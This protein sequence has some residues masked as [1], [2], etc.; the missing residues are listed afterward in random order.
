MHVALH[1]LKLFLWQAPLEKAVYPLRRL[2]T[3]GFSHTI[4][5]N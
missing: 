4:V 1:F 2:A 3:V 5:I